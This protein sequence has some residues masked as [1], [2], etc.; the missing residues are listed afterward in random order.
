M[1]KIN[2]LKI[3]VVFADKLHDHKGKIPLKNGEPRII[4]GY[5]TIFPI[6]HNE[7]VYK[8]ITT[9]MNKYARSGK[10]PS[11][12]KMTNYLD[13]LQNYCEYYNIENPSELL[14]ENIDERN[15]RLLNYLGE[16]IRSGRNQASVRNNYQS[17]IKSF[18][19]ARGSAL[20]DGLPTLDEG[21]NKNE[22]ILEKNTIRLI[23]NKLERAEYNLILKFE[24]LC[25]LRIGDILDELTTNKN[26]KA[27]YNLRKFNNHYYIDKFW[28]RKEDIIINFLFFPTELS[29]LLRATYNIRD[30]EKL[31]LRNILKTRN[32]TRI[33][34]YDFIERVK[35]I[36]KE[37]A[38]K[39]NI[40]NH[41]FRKYF[42]N[43]ISS[44]NLLN[45]NVKI[46]ADFENKF[47]EHLMAHKL[48]DLSNT[49]KQ[50]LKDINQFY[51]LWKPI[52]R[53]ICIDCEII[54]ETNEK[55]KEIN[56]K[57]DN[58]QEKFDSLIESDNQKDKEIQE[59]KDKLANMK[60][61]YDKKL[62]EIEKNMEKWVKRFKEYD[63]E[64][65]K[66]IIDEKGKSIGLEGSTQKILQDI[67]KS[68]KN[69]K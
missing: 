48:R 54:D 33:N 17:R 26:G 46:G 7:D 44:V 59:L 38:I 60:A 1:L 11:K 63:K 13:A 14:D 25:G 41:S 32:G 47:K 18:Y 55:V 68:K 31:D 6:L 42:S 64:K 43:E 5:Y 20:S 50:R 66:F 39:E 24:A 22:I 62:E 34:K 40:K 3:E 58:L 52:E 37:L 53:V 8:W 9:K 65:A 36:A 45:F 16:L 56:K 4:E 27:K 21:I 67:E 51:E 61:D 12:F 49:Y 2:G 10:N 29:N 35:K 69:K 28:T 30:L 23:Q 15:N 57:Y 19:S